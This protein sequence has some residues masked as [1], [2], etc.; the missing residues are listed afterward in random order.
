MVLQLAKLS[1]E[2]LDNNKLTFTLD[3]IKAACPDIMV[4]PG[5]LNGFGLLQAIKHFGLTGT[6]MTFNF[7]HLSI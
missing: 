7:L 5:A 6:T 4:V 1:L 3:D 2:A